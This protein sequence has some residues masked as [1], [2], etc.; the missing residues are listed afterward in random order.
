MD[1]TQK[2]IQK[3][4]P[5]IE[6]QIK[7]INQDKA[8]TF[9]SNI[10]QAAI[11]KTNP[12]L[13]FAP[14][15]TF[16][17]GVCE[18]LHL[19]YLKMTGTKVG[20][21]PK[22]IKKLRNLEILDLRCTAVT[23]LPIQLGELQKL[24]YLIVD[25]YW[26]NGFKVPTNI[27]NFSS[28][29]KLGTIDASGSNGNIIMGEVG[30]LTQLNTLYITKLRREDNVTLCSS[31]AKLSNLRS[32]YVSLIFMEESELEFLQLP[33]LSS[34]PSSLQKLFLDGPLEKEPHWIPSL[35]ILVRL[36][37]EGSKLRNEE[38]QCLQDLPIF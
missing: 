12:D 35:Q 22:S 29:Q 26:G 10:A 14:V 8:E 38:L 27:G 37:L 25:R 17:R 23:K 36:Q 34:C 4:E 13:S 6:S 20:V 16:P 7:T 32:L 1:G 9:G 11:N 15:D 19:K 3:L 28:L 5:N 2:V 21:F 33:S 18:L 30:M 31:L 24:R